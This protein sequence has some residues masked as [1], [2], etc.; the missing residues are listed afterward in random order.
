MT[1]FVW[2]CLVGL[3]LLT[4]GAYAQTSMS[5]KQQK[6]VRKADRSFEYFAFTAAAEGYARALETTPDN[7]TLIRQLARC[8][9]RLNDAAQTAYWY[10]Q[11]EDSLPLFTADDKL[12]YAQALASEQQYEQAGQWYAAY[13]ESSA[14]RQLA[15]TKQRAF[16]QLASFYQDSAFYSLT[17]AAVNS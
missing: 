2:L 16:E 8:Y 14:H 17:P 4:G 5:K 7:S 11:L 10:R 12:H 1:R 6:I 13:G 3:F 15:N 9:H